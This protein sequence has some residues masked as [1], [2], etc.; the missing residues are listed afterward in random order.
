MKTLRFALMMMLLSTFSTLAMAD[1]YD[2]YADGEDY[3]ERECEVAVKYT[4]LR[5]IL[6]NEALKIRGPAGVDEFCLAQGFDDSRVLYK[7]R[8][9]M[10]DYR[11]DFTNGYWEVTWGR[12]YIK[13]FE[14]ISYLSENGC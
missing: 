3:I 12:H 9:K 11:W 2:Y 8:K 13:I 5:L 14:C 7:H 10:K 1:Y 6:N 4:N